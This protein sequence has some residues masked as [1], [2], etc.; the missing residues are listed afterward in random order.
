MKQLLRDD[1]IDDPN[2]EPDF[3]KCPITLP[4][5]NCKQD[6]GL[7]KRSDQKP[8]DKK[9][10]TTLTDVFCDAAV[11]DPGFIFLQL[12][13][14]MP[15]LKTEPQTDGSKHSSQPATSTLQPTETKS[16]PDL[17]SVVLPMALGS[18]SPGH[19]PSNEVLEQ[20]PCLF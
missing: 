14:S 4:L 7:K 5:L 13:N 11:P 12:P 15:G 6:P 17:T 1:F 16:P 19:I 18:G 20:N 3:E 10:I 8:I 2:L 9:E